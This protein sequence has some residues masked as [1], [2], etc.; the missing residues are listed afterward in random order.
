MS[1]KIE[2]PT[3]DEFEK[4]VMARNQKLM[5][6]YNTMGMLTAPPELLRGMA[7]RFSKIAESVKYDSDEIRLKILREM[8]AYMQ[9]YLDADPIN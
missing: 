1:I 2:K 7:D 5:A 9:P 6:Q 8:Y 4:L 3:V